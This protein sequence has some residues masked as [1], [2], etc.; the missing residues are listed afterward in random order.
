MTEPNNHTLT[1]YQNEQTLNSLRNEIAS[2]KFRLTKK[3]ERIA[4]LDA[5][6]NTLMESHNAEV[7]AYE[8]LKDKLEDVI[9]MLKKKVPHSDIL[10]YLKAKDRNRLW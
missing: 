4:S 9:E 1:Y 10:D 2:L 3:D 6:L 5:L 8:D 7:R